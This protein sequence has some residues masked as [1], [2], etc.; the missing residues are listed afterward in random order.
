MLLS[1]GTGGAGPAGPR[2]QEGRGQEGDSATTLPHR[3][4]APHAQGQTL[5][6]LLARGSQQELTQN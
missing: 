2:V 4:V 1:V 6:Q 5:R 3:M